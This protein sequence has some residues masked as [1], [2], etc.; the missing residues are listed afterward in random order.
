MA[1]ISLLGVLV[2]HHRIFFSVTQ[3]ELSADV[4]RALSQALNED[5]YMSVRAATTIN[6]LDVKLSGVVSSPTVR[7]EVQRMVDAVHGVR[8]RVGDNRLQVRPHLEGALEGQRLSLQGWMPNEKA[9]TLLVNRL[10]ELRD[11]LEIDSTLVIYP[12][13][14]L[15]MEDMDSGK[16]PEILKPI[17]ELIQVSPHLE[18][19]A[20]GGHEALVVKGLLPKGP[21]EDAILLALNKAQPQKTV[22]REGLKSAGYIRDEGFTSSQRL[23][24]LL[25]K[26]FSGQ[27]AR[28]LR[29]EGNRLRLSGQVVASETASLQPLLT[30]LGGEIKTEQRFQVFPSVWHMPG[31]KPVSLI[32]EGVLISLRKELEQNVVFFL[33][34]EIEVID[35]EFGK[36]DRIAEA[37]MAAGPDVR[38]MVGG[39]PE[40]KGDF[41]EN[42]ISAAQ[43]AEAVVAALKERGVLPEVLQAVA[44]EPAP[45][46]YAAQARGVECFVK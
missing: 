31:Y 12:P 35:T 42:A 13:A 19:L 26:F 30:A 4:N 15:P 29:V 11:G 16:L 27:G 44:F 18:I 6:Y 37:V 7:L 41:A 40:T 22:Q 14:V 10:K 23:P 45:G 21:L 9:L 39:C 36:L 8:C 33:P 28:T 46:A 1:L 25:E 38:L 24:D 3:D 17:W 43:R 32:D 2:L 34:G 5:D 20:E